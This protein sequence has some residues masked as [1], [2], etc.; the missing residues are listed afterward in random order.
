MKELLDCGFNLEAAQRVSS[1]NLKP[2]YYTYINKNVAMCKLLL[3][4]EVHVDSEIYYNFTLLHLAVESSDEKFIKLALDNGADVN[5]TIKY[6]HTLLHYISSKGNVR[7][8]KLLVNH[9]ANVNAKDRGGFTPLHIVLENCSTNILQ[10]VDLLL[11]NK[12][13][14]NATSNLRLTPLHFAVK[15]KED[16]IIRRLLKCGADIKVKNSEGNNALYIAIEHGCLSQVNMFLEKEKL[17][18]LQTCVI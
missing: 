8:A 17:S 6:Y 1:G 18:S 16:E 10:L 4:N 13:D 3:A 7:I 5:R 14:V 11:Q 2:M 15:C 12:C 9:N